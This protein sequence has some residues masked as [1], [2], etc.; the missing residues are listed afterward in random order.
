MK[1][2]LQ[3]WRVRAVQL[4]LARQRETISAIGGFIR[5]ARDWG[6]NMLV[7]YLE[8]NPTTPQPCSG[9]GRRNSAPF[10]ATPGKPPRC[11]KR[12]CFMG[13]ILCAKLED[14]I[15]RRREVTRGLLRLFQA[16]Q[17]PR[18]AIH[19][20][21]A[22]ALDRSPARPRAVHRFGFRRAGN[23]LRRRALCR[24]LVCAGPGDAPERA[25]RSSASRVEDDATVCCLGSPDTVG[26]LTSHEE[27]AESVLE[28]SLAASQRRH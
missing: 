4:D 17:P 10:C 13:I 16:G 22:C 18:R 26:A 8:G 15:A 19:P 21:S 23:Q 24:P 11:C 27:A 12:G 2:A 9:I 28:I 7:L 14:R 1:T 25:D 20:A 5:F 6:C 3:P